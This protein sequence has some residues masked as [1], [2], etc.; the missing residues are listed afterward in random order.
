MLPPPRN[1][2]R[3]GES[4][5]LIV[6]AV[7]ALESDPPEGV[8]P[9]EWMLLTSEPVADFAASDACVDWYARRWLMEEWHKVEKTGC[10]LETAQLKDAQALERLAA[11]TAVVGVRLLQLRNLARSGCG[12]TSLAADAR[13]RGDR[14][15]AV[16]NLRRVVPG[17]WLL[18][19]AQLARGEPEKLTPELFW[20][21]VAK[22]GGFI[23]RKSDGWP[24]WQTIWRGW[25]KICDIVLGL[26][27]LREKQEGGSYG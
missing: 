13:S 6:W 2:P 12:E 11:L 19:V 5:P 23:G 1:D 16:A 27:I 10:R 25:S 9:L 22:Q 3:F 7:Y 20:L 26:Q 15:R 18:V 17:D 21:T 24:G 4:K 14:S 8:D